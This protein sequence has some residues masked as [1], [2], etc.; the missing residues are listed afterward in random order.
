MTLLEARTLGYGAS[1]RNGGIVHPGY[2]WGPLALIRRYGNDTGRAL[3]RES[4]D[5]YETVKRLI[6]EES[7]DCEFRE[8]GYLK[9]AYAPS[10]VEELAS[11][12]RRARTDGRERG[13]RSA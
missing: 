7:I 8:R 1:T 10:H 11:R 13:A 9:L 12:Q 4:V 3:F 5:S 2:K 6:I